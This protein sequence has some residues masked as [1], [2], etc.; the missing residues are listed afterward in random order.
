M[1]SH[2]AAGP[3]EGIQHEEWVKTGQ[4]SATAGHQNCNGNVADLV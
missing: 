3:A 1:L 2:S 4:G